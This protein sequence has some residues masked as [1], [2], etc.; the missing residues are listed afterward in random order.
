[1]PLKESESS[2]GSASD[3][4]SDKQA[5]LA[6]LRQRIRHLDPGVAWRQGCQSGPDSHVCPPASSPSTSSPPV[7]SLGI[8]SIDGS[9]PGGGLYAHGLHEVAAGDTS[10]GSEA[11]ARAAASGFAAFLL[12]RLAHHNTPDRRPGSVLWCCRRRTRRGAGDLYA[13]GMLTYGLDH[14]RLLIARGLSSRQ[15]LWAMEEGLASNALAAVI[16]EPGAAGPVALRRLQ[17]A[18]EAGRTAAV[19]L[20]SERA[21]PAATPAYTRWRVSPLPRPIHHDNTAASLHW[22]VE[23][24]KCRGGRPATWTLNEDD[25]GH[26]TSTDKPLEHPHGIIPGI[27]PAPAPGAVPLAGG[28]R[29]RPVPQTMP[30]A[31]SRPDGELRCTG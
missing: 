18:A 28:I 20:L 26:K 25:L 21:L 4:D 24:L 19:L 23:L 15:V 11:S 6:A 13:P 17:L 29:H 7:I 14:E 22:R 5:M 16:G 1:M 27:T 2:N 10:R 30:V 12:A 3:S 31:A 8:S 9:L